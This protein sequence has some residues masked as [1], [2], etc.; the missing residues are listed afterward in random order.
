[1]SSDILLV[2]KQ[3][4]L[5]PV[6]LLGIEIKLWILIALGVSFAAFA[7]I[8]ILCLCCS[9]CRTKK[10]SYD[11]PNNLVRNNTDRSR[12]SESTKGNKKSIIASPRTSSGT[13]R[14]D[15][16]PRASTQ[17]DGWRRSFSLLAIEIATNELSRDNVIG[18]GDSGT[19][20][21]GVL[22]DG[23]NVAI[24]KLLVNR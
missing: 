23:T 3:K 19:V 10:P 18:H 9:L 17:S 8:T 5:M 7:S 22:L 6:S 24:K 2:V 14:I 4:L 11:R 16:E 12:S 13:H 20:Y 1:M 21:H 15:V